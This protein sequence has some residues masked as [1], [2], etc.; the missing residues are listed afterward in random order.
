MRSIIQRY[1]NMRI[2]STKSSNIASQTGTPVK[3]RDV[4]RA[5]G[6][7]KPDWNASE[8]QDPTEK[9]RFYI[10]ETAVGILFRDIKL[11]APPEIPQGK[12]I[13]AFQRII[14]AA[15]ERQELSP[16]P[17]WPENKTPQQR[18]H[19]SEFP[20]LPITGGAS[21]HVANSIQ[22]G[23]GASKSSSTIKFVAHNPLPAMT[24]SL[25]A[26]ST[27]SGRHSI[28]HPTSLPV[29]PSSRIAA[30]GIYSPGMSYPLGI[31]PPPG[32][33]AP[34]GFFSE[35]GMP[36]PPGI[37]PPGL[38][39][40]MGAYSTPSLDTNFDAAHLSDQR[41]RTVL[42][43]LAASHVDV[44]EAPVAMS[45]EI[46]LAYGRYVIELQCISISQ[47]LAENLTEEEVSIE[48]LWKTRLLSSYIIWSIAGRWYRYGQGPTVP[49]ST[50][51]HCS[52]KSSDIAPRPRTPANLRWGP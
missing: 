49:P 34:A 41:L 38:Q 28:T 40:S 51:T 25:D 26:A 47:A 44:D 15:E 14:D 27:I 30:P 50:R 16:P 46:Q 48:D 45:Q 39:A 36:L 52:G 7:E 37:A 11:E 9:S 4:P 10:S 24:S 12:A 42:K 20:A 1:G 13:P 23:R 32:L 29:G 22:S 8:L 3:L 6:S 43:K 2:V 18:L 35:P 19:P 21:R 5:L 31:P 33:S 17:T